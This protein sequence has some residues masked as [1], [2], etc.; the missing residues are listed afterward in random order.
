MNVYQVRVFERGLPMYRKPFFVQASSARDA[1]DQ[2]ERNLGLEPPKIVWKD[3][4]IKGKV[5]RKAFLIGRYI[6]YRCKIVL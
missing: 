6:E 3:V 2:V 4:E 5:Q 1:C